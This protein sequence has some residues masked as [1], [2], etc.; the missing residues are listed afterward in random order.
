[1]LA[2]SGGN[3]ARKA[4]NMAEKTSLTLMSGERIVMS[5]DG[6]TLI[7]TNMRI[8]LSAKNSGNS[9]LVSITLDAVA[10]CGLATR[11][12]PILLL[13][14]L[15]AVLSGLTQHNESQLALIGIGALLLLAYFPSR[16]AVMTIAS[17][18]K[19]EIIVPASGIGRDAIIEFIDALEVEKIRFLGRNRA[20]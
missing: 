4:T 16:N 10:A 6:D 13:L 18:G 1:M 14:G 2:D 7:L 17:S 11:S 8:R 19:P 3:A 12:Y 9:K 5:S 20:P 15:C